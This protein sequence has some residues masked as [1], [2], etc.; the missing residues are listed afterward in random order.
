MA[1]ATAYLASASA[2]PRPAASLPT[3]SRQISGRTGRAAAAARFATLEKNITPHSLR[4]S[5]AT[6]LMEAG[7]DLIEVQKFLGHHSILTTARYTHLTDQTK[8]H[9]IERINGL[10]DRF[11][12]AWGNVK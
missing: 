7:V 2:D 11:P 8:H 1:R 4:H 3:Q 6:H 5:Y 12:I 10:M 9:A